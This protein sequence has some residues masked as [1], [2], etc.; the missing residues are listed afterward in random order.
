MVINFHTIRVYFE[1]W[2]E[3]VTKQLAETVGSYF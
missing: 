2:F 1:K 3:R